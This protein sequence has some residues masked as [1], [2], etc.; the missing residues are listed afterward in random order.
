MLRRA[1]LALPALTALLAQEPIHTDLNRRLREEG[2]QKSQVMALASE[3]VDG[4]GPR[5]MGSPASV[6]SA[7]WMVARMKGWGL[8]A[9]TERFDF[10]HPGWT[11]SWCTAHVVAPYQDPLTVEVVAWTPATKGLVKG[12]AF[13]LTLPVEPTAAELDNLFT[14]LK[15][16]LKGRM[17]LVGPHEVVPPTLTPRPLRLDAATLA[18]RL[19][20]LKEPQPRNFDRPR[21]K[22]EGALEPREI[23]RRLDAFLVAEGAAVRIDDARLPNGQIRAFNNR[24]YDV[25]Q[26]VPTVVMRSEDFGRM[27]RQMAAGKAVTLAFDI[28]TELHPQH[29]DGLNVV[30][31]LKG[32]EKPEEVIILGAH[33]DSWHTATGATDNGGNCV[34]MME[35]LRLLKTAGVTPRRTIRVV[36]FDGEE[37]GLL[38][39]TAYVKAH[40]GMP[41]APK[42]AGDQ[43]VAMFNM[44]AGTGQMRGLS[45]FG[46]REA[47]L[48]LHDVLAPWQDLGVVSASWHRSRPAKPDHADITV[49]SHRGIPAIGPTQ[50]P[51]EYFNY[52]WHTTLDTYERLVPEDMKRN[53][54][55]VASLAFHLADRKERLPRFEGATLPPL[56]RAK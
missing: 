11:H 44:D 7:D 17:V 2:L 48:V 8:E 25:K 6:A 5:L 51:M 3:L 36:L 39:S 52:T 4:F 40:Y 14:G 24:T 50:D 45:L 18:E 10:G 28:R 13:A 26:A 23:S 15:G 41:D 34:V 31:E 38:G 43:V 32:S 20:P 12:E 22:R 53:A 21:P 30:A 37:L 9:W 29:R 47:A 27:W 19:N 33:R 54:T 16:R 35:A 42:P 46:P 56:P 55:L 1:F 49:F